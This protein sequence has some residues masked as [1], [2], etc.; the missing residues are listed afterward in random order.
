MTSIA[1]PSGKR[2]LGLAGLAMFVAAADLR[3]AIAAVSPW[4]T[5]SAPTWT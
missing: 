2:T 1:S 4:W 3:P 5:A